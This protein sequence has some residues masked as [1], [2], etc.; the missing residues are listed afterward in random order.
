VHA[1]SALRRR[2][3][4]NQ[5]ATHR[6]VVTSDN[7]GIGPLLLSQQACRPRRRRLPSTRPPARVATIPVSIPPEL[8][9]S[10]IWHSCELPVASERPRFSA[11]NQFANVTRGPERASGPSHAG[12]RLEL[13]SP[14][15]YALRLSFC[16]QASRI[17]P[18]VDGNRTH[19]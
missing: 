2:H 6:R 16:R 11:H 7:V 17:W 9:L 4:K 14:W 1:I 13:R 10:A 19:P 18:R 15:L 12:L 3:R 8:R 5:A